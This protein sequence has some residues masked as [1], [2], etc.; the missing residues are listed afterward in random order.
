M[1]VSQHTKKIAISQPARPRPLAGA[2]R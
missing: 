1:M 2:L